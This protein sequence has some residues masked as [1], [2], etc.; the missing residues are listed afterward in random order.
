MA[1]F[2]FACLLVGSWYQAAVAAESGTSTSALDAQDDKAS[3]QGVWVAQSLETEGKPDSGTDTRQMRMRFAFKGD[4]LLFAVNLDLIVEKQ[5]SYRID[6]TKSPKHLD[7]T[8]DKPIQGETTLGIYELKGDELKV[9]LR[10]GRTQSGRPTDFST[11]AD[12][13]LIL[14]VFKRAKAK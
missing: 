4:K 8:P 11:N 12:S 14:I 2:V 1:R 5:W 7:I 13:G 6:A 3:L 10:C 9:C